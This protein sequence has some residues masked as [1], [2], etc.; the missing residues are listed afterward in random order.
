M[1][2]EWNE[3]VYAVKIVEQKKALEIGNKN[4]EEKKDSREKGRKI[5]AVDENK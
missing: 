3:I 4:C 5:V 1:K 2:N